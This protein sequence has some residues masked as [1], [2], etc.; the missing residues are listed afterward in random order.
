MNIQRKTF[1]NADRKGFFGHCVI[2]FVWPSNWLNFLC[3]CCITFY[4]FVLKFAFGQD[5]SGGFDFQSSFFTH[6]TTQRYLDILLI[7]VFTQCFESPSIL[8]VPCTS[9]SEIHKNSSNQRN[10]CMYIYLFIRNLLYETQTLR[11]TKI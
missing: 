6:C 9:W 10:A 11:S 4:Y 2:W 8:F 7:D 3:W 5:S 1:L